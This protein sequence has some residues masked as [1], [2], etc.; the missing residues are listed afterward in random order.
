[1][2]KQSIENNVIK[3]QAVRNR[4][5]TIP[6][7]VPATAQQVKQGD[8]DGYANFSL[9]KPHTQPVKIFSELDQLARQSVSTMKWELLISTNQLRDAY[10][11]G[12]SYE[13]DEAFR[14]MMTALFP[15]EPEQKEVKQTMVQEI[16]EFWSDPAWTKRIVPTNLPPAVTQEMS[17]ARLVLWWNKDQGRFLPAI[18]C[19]DY[20]TALFV[21]GAMRD[22]R[23][24]PGCDQ[25]FVVGRPDQEYHTVACRERHR[26]RKF[27]KLHGKKKAH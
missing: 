18:F 16:A 17:G 11:Q 1:M 10:E 19:E 12:K 2:G 8:F 20:G 15:D 22:L 26:Q 7:L 24:C 14:K 5:T 6:I 27:Y 13:I 25:A 9:E 3:H 23:A 21:R 4:K